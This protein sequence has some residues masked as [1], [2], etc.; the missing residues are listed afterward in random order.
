MVI[1]EARIH[2]TI[3]DDKPCRWTA[4]HHHL[5][6]IGTKG[7]SFRTQ[8][9]HKSGKLALVP[10]TASPTALHKLWH[11]TENRTLEARSMVLLNL[12]FR[13]TSPES[14]VKKVYPQ[15]KEN[16]SLLT[17]SLISVSYLKGLCTYETPLAGLKESKSVSHQF[18]SKP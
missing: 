5:L 12:Y 7:S 2:S 14:W 10:E 11:I 9:H 15:H 13:A 3:T 6:R 16:V 18:E 4:A 8:L 1:A 17:G